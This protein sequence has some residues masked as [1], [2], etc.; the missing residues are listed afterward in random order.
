MSYVLH[1][2]PNIKQANPS[3]LKPDLYWDSLIFLLVQFFPT[4]WNISKFPFF[5]GLGFLLNESSSRKKSRSLNPVKCLKLKVSKLNQK[6][7]VSGRIFPYKCMV[8]L[9]TFG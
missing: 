1:F 2:F 5:F 6:E 4:T 8:D 7:G 3:F 9:P